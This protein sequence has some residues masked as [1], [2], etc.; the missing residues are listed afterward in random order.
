MIERVKHSVKQATVAHAVT[1]NKTKKIELQVKQINRRVDNLVMHARHDQLKASALINL[2]NQK[3][4]QITSVRQAVQAEQ[5]P[6]QQ[7]QKVPNE[8][9]A[10]AAIIKAIVLAKVTKSLGTLLLGYQIYKRIW[11]SENG[12]IQLDQQAIN[13]KP[14]VVGQKIEITSGSE[15]KFIAP[16][17]I[18]K[19]QTIEFANIKGQSTEAVIQTNKN[20]SRAGTSAPFGYGVRRN[21]MKRSGGYS[22]SGTFNRDSGL[23][24][25][26]YSGGGTP[27]PSTA[28]RQNNRT[29][30]PQPPPQ[31]QS[32]WQGGS[33]KVGLTEVPTADS[34][35]IDRRQFD[36]ELADPRVRAALA[37]R[38]KIEVG[39]Q[40]AA[41]QMWIES[42]LNRAS[43]RRRSIIST[44]DNSD[45]YYPRK[46]DGKF[47]QMSGSPA[48]GHW[49]Q[50]IDKVHKGSDLSRGATGNSSEY[51]GFGQGSARRQADGSIWAP[52]QTAAAGG[53][54]FGREKPD[55]KWAPKY[56]PAGDL[57]PDLALVKP[58][59]LKALPDEPKGI[60]KIFQPGTLGRNAPETPDQIGQLLHKATPIFRGIA[61]NEEENP[62]ARRAQT[63][64]S[65]RSFSSMGN[66]LPEVPPVSATPVAKPKPM[67]ITDFAGMVPPTQ[68]QQQSARLKL[69]N[70]PWFI[71]D[72]IA[73]GQHGNYGG[74]GS[75]KADSDGYT[76]VGAGPAAIRNIIDAKLAD[77]K[78]LQSMRDRGVVFSGGASNDPKQT[79]IA[80]EQI[81][82]LRDAGIPVRVVGV[83]NSVPGSEQI[84]QQLREAAGQGNFI[85]ITKMKGDALHPVIPELKQAIDQ[86]RE[87]EQPQQPQQ[88]VAPTTPPPAV[89]AVPNK[90]IEQQQQPVVAPDRF[91]FKTGST[92]TNREIDSMIG[93]HGSNIIIGQNHLDN[94]SALA[95]AKQKGAKTYWYMIGEG[96]PAKGYTGGGV[97]F[98]SDQKEVADNMREMGFTSRSQ[99]DKGG[100]LEWHK[101]KLLEAKAD[102]RLPDYVEFDSI[103][104]GT[105]QDVTNMLV[106][107]DKW[108]KE[109][110]IPTQL[111][112]K[113]MGQMTYPLIDREIQAGRL[114][115]DLFAPMHLFEE[116]ASQQYIKDS[117]KWFNKHGWHLFQTS[118]TMNYSSPAGGFVFDK[119]ISSKMVPGTVINTPAPVQPNIMPPT[120]PPPTRIPP[121]FVMPN[122]APVTTSVPPAQ[123]GLLKQQQEQQQQQQEQQK[124]EE[125]KEQEVVPKVVDQPSTGGGKGGGGKIV[126]EPTP[127]AGPPKIVAP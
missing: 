46:D 119:A 94:Q 28:P 125:E 41:Q 10:I 78:Q 56:L 50:L 123:A 91:F 16:E 52:G 36:A 93:R 44:V 18:F 63:P 61:N 77:P 26:P 15:L 80:I 105:A 3:L 121:G 101:K 17:I 116:Y 53:E 43:S 120:T 95:Y 126:G 88:Q 72:S 38:A 13:D 87:V 90:P 127:A 73:G 71:G 54:R 83:R 24:Q 57:L 96:E 23:S 82:K 48:G 124:K 37:A 31:A 55:L 51:V 122:G 7:V 1:L 62:F 111:V 107:F 45:G 19:A 68:Q 74:S 27:R 59:V 60:P 67:S 58:E 64:Y 70:K 85:D 92:Y 97:R 8:S 2:F 40:P 79:A 65:R 39:S 109:N 34:G 29:T 35:M 117:S 112:T 110:G 11:P 32:I 100:W 115:K 4:Q 113:N 118:D 49:D 6:Q 84:N 114:S 5:Q 69:S 21:D 33:T 99:W 66:M 98:P 89:N 25:T 12:S 20:I 103:N 76:H 47:R 106:N 102:G 14:Y 22:P 75:I 108:R 86:S 104:N 42:V 30:E 81:K 9:G